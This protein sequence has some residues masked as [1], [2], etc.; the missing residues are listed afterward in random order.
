MLTNAKPLEQQKKSNK[1]SNRDQVETSHLAELAKL[2]AVIK[3]LST[4]KETIEA[5]IKEDA[6]AKFVRDANCNHKRPANYTGIDGEAT[7]S[8]ELRK[9]STMS[10]LSENEV[11]YLKSNGVEVEKVV[12]APKLF[13]INPKY[14]GDEELMNKVEKKL[15]AALEGLVGDDFFVVQEERAKYVVSDETIDATFKKDVDETLVKMVATLAIKPKLESFD[16]HSAMA[17]I[18]ETLDINDE[19]DEDE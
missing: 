11:A 15:V 12:E 7:A 3:S 6:L 4:L 13:A 10:K 16:M 5:S 19:A 1:K 17:S 14:A 18:F 8:I 9:R 2:D